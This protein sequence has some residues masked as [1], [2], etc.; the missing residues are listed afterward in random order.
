MYIESSVSYFEARLL[1]ECVLDIGDTDIHG[2]SVR[3]CHCNILN[4]LIRFAGS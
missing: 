1:L 2:Y 4:P 3:V